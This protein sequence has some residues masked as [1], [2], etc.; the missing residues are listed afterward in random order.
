MGQCDTTCQTSMAAPVDT[1]L[2]AVATLLGS[3][4]AVAA[5]SPRAAYRAARLDSPRPPSEQVLQPSGAIGEPRPA[6][7]RSAEEQQATNETVYDVLHDAALGGADF[8]ASS[9][10]AAS[11]PD[12][13]SSSLSA[14]TDHE[15]HERSEY[16]KR[17]RAVSQLLLVTC[18]IGLAVMPIFIYDPDFPWRCCA[19]AMPRG[20][21]ALRRVQSAVALSWL[22]VWA[23]ETGP[24]LDGTPKAKR[25]EV[26]GDAPEAGAEAGAPEAAAAAGAP[27]ATAAA[28]TAAA[29]A[30][31][32]D[33]KESKE[34]RE[35]CKSS[36]A[37]AMYGLLAFAGAVLVGAMLGR[38]SL[39][40]PAKLRLSSSPGRTRTAI[41]TRPCP[42][43]PRSPPTCSWATTTSSARSPRSSP[44]SPRCWV[45]AGERAPRSRPPSLSARRRRGTI[46][47]SST[48]SPPTSSPRTLR[49]TSG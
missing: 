21:H 29:A 41:A 24:L 2:R 3:V 45:A 47:A 15:S 4:L 43:H 31:A 49:P 22:H 7:S 46:R 39:C 9:D 27:E 23:W 11:A 10:T 20:G 34:S 28:A 40:A 30:A 6:T 17:D 42:T 25:R 12:G 35:G 37:V 19:S 8:N 26:P 48:P 36:A 32:R 5:S 18:L 44:A 38:L 1:M 33:R 14:E 13:D 16:I